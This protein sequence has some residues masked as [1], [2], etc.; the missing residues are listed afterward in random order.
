MSFFG[1]FHEIFI[2]LKIYGLF[3]QFIIVK[4][5]NYSDYQPIR[6]VL[7]PFPYEDA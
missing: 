7:I 1:N 4:L 2:K 3:R 6:L 5:S